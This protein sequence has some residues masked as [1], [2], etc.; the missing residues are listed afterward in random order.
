MGALEVL[1]DFIYGRI[2]RR[3]CSMGS[4]GDAG[5]SIIVPFIIHVTVCCLALAIVSL[6]VGVPD[7]VGPTIPLRLARLICHGGILFRNG[8]KTGQHPLNGV[9]ESSQARSQ[10]DEQQGQR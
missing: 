4:L 3:L 8:T 10:T 2:A 6:V 9:E 7:P 5:R 1:A